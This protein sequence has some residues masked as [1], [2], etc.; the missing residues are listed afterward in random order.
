MF[1]TEVIVRPKYIA[2]DELHLS[3]LVWYNGDG[4]KI[5]E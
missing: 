4:M 5:L 1:G 3:P 2:K